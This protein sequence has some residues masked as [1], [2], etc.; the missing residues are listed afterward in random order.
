MSKKP[1]NKPRPK[2]LLSNE[3]PSILDW[4]DGATVI[5]ANFRAPANRP[6][7]RKPPRNPEK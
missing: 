4:L 5:Q 2:E 3:D 7:R 1:T 6:K